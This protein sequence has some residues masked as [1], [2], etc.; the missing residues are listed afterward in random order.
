MENTDTSLLTA[1]TTSAAEDAPGASARQQALD[2]ERPVALADRLADPVGVEHQRRPRERGRPPRI[3]YSSPSLDAERQPALL[4]HLDGPSARR[5]SARGCAAVA[6][7]KR[8]LSG[9]T[10][11]TTAVAIVKELNSPCV[12]WS[13]TTASSSTRRL[14]RVGERVQAGEQR[15]EGQRDPDPVAGQVDDPQRHS[16]VAQA[17]LEE[18]VAA[19][20]RH[21]LAAGRH[22]ERPVARDRRRE[23]ALLDLRRDLQLAHQ[24]RGVLRLLDQDPVREGDARE[25]G[26]QLH[27]LE[28]LRA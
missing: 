6:T 12:S 28:L 16:A 13:F 22:L 8:P 10:K 21:R 4:Q 14:D 9:S 19:H 23:E 2:P 7:E 24:A 3:G 11:A 26:Q 18:T 27:E 25:V 17:P 1:A 5:T 20:L 15:R